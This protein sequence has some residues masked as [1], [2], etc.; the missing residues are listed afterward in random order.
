MK[1][2]GSAAKGGPLPDLCIFKCMSCGHID[3]VDADAP[4]E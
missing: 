1:F 4:S 3:T 2:S